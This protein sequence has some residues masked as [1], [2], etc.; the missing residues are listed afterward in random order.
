MSSLRSA[1]EELAVTDLTDCSSEDLRDDVAEIAH[2][3]GRLTC[4][5]QRRTLE[6]AH[7]G[8]HARQG[9]VNPVRWLAVT[10]DVPD[11]QAQR[12][13]TEGR[14]LQGF[15]DT[16]AAYRSGD[17]SGWRASLLARAAARHPHLYRRDEGVLVG[18]TRELSH[19]D[20]ARAVRH[21]INCADQD[22]AAA[23]A[24]ARRNKAYLHASSTFDGMVRVD[25]LLDQTDGEALLAALE[26]A[27]PPPSAHDRRAASNRRSAALGEICRQWLANGTT[28][29][30]GTRPHVTLVVDLETLHG[31]TGRHCHLT[32]TGPLSPRTALQLLC[33]AS[34]SRLVTTGA[35]VPLDLGRAVR[36]ATPAQRRA[37]AIRDGG[38][39]APGCDRPPHWCDAHH[40]RHWIHGG[41]SDLDNLVL[42]CR[43]HHTMTHDGRL[44]ITTTGGTI[45]IE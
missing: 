12:L 22:S 40:I 44:T 32:H 37:L 34:L 20:V 3:I 18:L 5:L 45:Q 13:L 23:D 10:A 38:C 19:R 11:H 21:W 16:Q 42:L 2:Q 35:S 9:F 24:T 30:G 1:V 33:D 31:R 43:H 25:G 28:S 8:D 4:Q 7:R 6:V 41:P 17:L 14:A 36:T 39:A 29:S 27:T 26:A 15:A